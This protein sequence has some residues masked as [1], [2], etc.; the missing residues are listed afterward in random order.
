MTT[1]EVKRLLSDE[2]IYQ[3]KQLCHDDDN[4]ETLTDGDD[5]DDDNELMEDVLDI[6]VDY[7][8]ICDAAE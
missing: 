5:D 8:L 4:D 3:I 6:S 7:G 2:D 1:T